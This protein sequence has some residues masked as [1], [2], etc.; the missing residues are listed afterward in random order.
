[1]LQPPVATASPAAM[2]PPLLPHAPHARP[3]KYDYPFDHLLEL[4]KLALGFRL[5]LRQ[6][7]G[8]QLLEQCGIDAFVEEAASYW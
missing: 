1:M 2:P 8:V 3:L 5:H 6:P 4:R 7:R